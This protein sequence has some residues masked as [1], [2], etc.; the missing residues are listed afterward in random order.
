M[1]FGNG[2]GGLGPDGV[3]DAAVKASITG[4]LP[5]KWGYL[6]DLVDIW[7]TEPKGPRPL[8]FTRQVLQTVGV[9]RS[10]RASGGEE[11]PSP[12]DQWKED[13]PE[14]SLYFDG[15]GPLWFWSVMEG[16]PRTVIPLG[17]REH[18]SAKKV[19]IVLPSGRKAVFLFSHL[20]PGGPSEKNR[21]GIEGP[22]FKHDLP[23]NSSGGESYKRILNGF[24]EEGRTKF[25]ADFRDFLWS[26]AKHGYTF[27]YQSNPWDGDQVVITQAPPPNEYV[28][29]TSGKVWSS[30]D[31]IV[32]RCKLFQACGESRKLLYYGPPGTGK[33]TLARRIGHKVGGNRVLRIES[34]A[35]SRVGD[36]LIAKYVAMLSP[37]VI[38]IDDLDRNAHYTNTLLHYLEKVDRDSDLKS[39][40]VIG[41]VNSI[42]ELDPA[43]L[44]PGRFDEV[45]EIDV[46]SPEQTSRV[47]RHYL[48]KYGI[49]V[50]GHDMW[51]DKM[52]GFA[53][54]DIREVLSCVSKVGVENADMEIERVNLQ[55]ELHSGTRVAEYFERRRAGR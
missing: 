9:V 28:A 1:N 51:V 15:P 44:R 49:D 21:G 39:V 36:N 40:V 41:T 30:L 13:H 8:H 38:V 46:P 29:D 27:Y 25:A 32:D 18:S 14:F 22:Y 17:D 12:K 55:R 24:I 20:W 43:L 48:E 5:G 2:D 47:I 52:K 11:P 45:H 16:L 31:A 6:Q 50:S 23:E 53:P 10:M 42:D 33:T 3:V 37:R 35:M 54:A 34:S 4:R 26:S 7:G 19:E